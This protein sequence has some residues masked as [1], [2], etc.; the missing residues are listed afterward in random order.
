MH[1]SDSIDLGSPKSSSICCFA[2]RSYNRFRGIAN[3]IKRRYRRPQWSGPVT[4]NEFV[5][6]V[7]D[8]AAQERPVDRHWRPYYQLCQP[9]QKNYDFIGHY[10]TLKVDADYVL[11]KLGVRDKISFEN[12]SRR[13]NSSNY[14]RKY[15]ASVPPDHTRKLYQH[16]RID[17]DLFGYKLSL[18]HI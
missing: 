4:F 12:A 13:H 17:F 10:E 18:I 16:F 8:P 9:C 5:R 7:L 6:Y 14:V 15:F 1:G 11:R 3:K 2:C